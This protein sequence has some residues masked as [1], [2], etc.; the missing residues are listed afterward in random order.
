MP[1][2]EAVNVLSLDRE[3]SV[4]GL[5]HRR[6]P[7]TGVDDT[8]YSLGTVIHHPKSPDSSKNIE[9]VFSGHAQGDVRAEVLLEPGPKMRFHS[10]RIPVVGDEVNLYTSFLRL[11]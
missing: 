10:F 4:P 3:L 6:R 7:E 5:E 9:L 8:P 2:G 1:T 11:T